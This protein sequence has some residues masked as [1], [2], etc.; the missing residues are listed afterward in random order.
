VT[1]GFNPSASEKKSMYLKIHQTPK[2]KIVAACDQEI[3]GTVLDDGRIYLDLKTHRGFYSGSLVDDKELREALGNF[4]S[5]N[6]VGKR[7]V[8]VAIE[9][10]IA[11]K[12]D[13]MYINKT[14]HIQLYRI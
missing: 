1:S 2:G 3:L 7:A 13:V 6:L 4:V 12:E 11:D 8:A 9:M 5:A 14:P 10:N